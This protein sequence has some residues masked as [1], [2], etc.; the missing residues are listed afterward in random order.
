M[1]DRSP[2]PFLSTTAPPFARLAAAASDRLRRTPPTI[3]LSL[4]VL[5]V[6]V[7]CA[8]S[9]Q[10]GFANKIPPHYI[11]PLWPTN[12]ILFAV[13]VVAPV[14]HW[15]AYVCAAYFMA[16]VNDARAGF[17]IFAMLYLAAD[18]VEVA[19]AAFGVRR[20]AGGV[21]SFD[22]LS[23]LLTYIVIAVVLAPFVSAFV[24]AFAGSTEGYWF[25][26]RV[27]FLAESL[28]YLTLAPVILTWIRVAPAAPANASFGRF[29][30][31]CVIAGGLLAISVRVFVWPAPD[32]GSVPALVYLPLPF[33]LWAAVR[34]GPPGVN[35]AL[36]IVAL[37][38]ITGTVQGRG[39]FATGGTDENV[40][41]L[42]VFLIVISLPL[43][44][45]GTLIAERDEKTND[46][47]ESEARFRTMADSA[48]VLIWMSDEDKRCIFFNRSWLEFTGRTLEQ[49]FGNG[50]SEGVHADDVEQCLATY[51]TAFEAR[52]EFALEYRLRR[53]DGEYRWIFDKG[54]P[55]FA[56]DGT[57]LGYIGC[58]D[59]VTDRRRA[60]E[61]AAL[62]RQEVA[63]LM[64]T[65]V[66][67]ELSGAI[68]HEV[69]QPLTAIL[70]NA[71]AALQLIAQEK[72]DL[73]EIRDA[74][75]DIVKEDNRAGEVI[76]RL[77]NLLRKG[78]R[79]SEPVD[80]NE[81]VRSTVALLNSELIGRRINVK[82]ELAGILPPTSG[83][84]V[85]LQQ[86][87]LNLLMNAMD[88]MVSTPIAQRLVTIS[89][90]ATPAGSVEV[91]VKDG[92][93]G[94]G[95]MQQDQL[96]QPF[97]TTKSHGL[98]LGLTI[99]ST[100]VQAHGGKLSLANDAAGGAVASFSLPAAEMLIAAQ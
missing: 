99:C 32:E 88:A 44:L 68:A 85:Q 91:L 40:I 22:S 28:A 82:T 97:Y 76:H 7:V 79:K 83:D 98:G 6:G 12:A 57:F 9:T 58:A 29:V 73:A 31:A 25:Y 47:S 23:G 17:P 75:A 10:I 78:E 38:S 70:S 52:R 100:I 15:W 18:L 20:F 37:L 90:R 5:M 34:F 80:V 26:W 62:Q 84:P 3:R 61:D 27:W 16:V 55:R 43:M 19:M 49:E 1:T 93:T 46:L 11:S 72:P 24:A 94:I 54:V 21:R 65:S 86:V 53:H 87:L 51:V 89:T 8:L 42:Q 96:F 59:D 2:Q 13:L 39:P 35:A 67:G 56:P 60:E 95:P 48:P 71:Q 77:R 63:H 45:L 50:W 36:L 81:L 92:G 30:E 41:S 74:L 69:N 33:L 4:N 66:L 14:R 64:R